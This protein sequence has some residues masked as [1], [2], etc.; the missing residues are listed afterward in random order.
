MKITQL[1]AET[2]LENSENIEDKVTLADD[3]NLIRVTLSRGKTAEFSKPT[4]IDL[5]RAENQTERF[6]GEFSMEFYRALARICC[7]RWGE[8]SEMPESEFIR[9]SD[10]NKMILEWIKHFDEAG[11]L[12]GDT[13][14]FTQLLD[15]GGLKPGFDAVEATLLNGDTLKFDEPSQIENQMLEKSDSTIEGNIILMSSLCRSWNGE[16]LS[17]A[18]YRVKINRLGLTDFLRL[19]K[20]LSFFQ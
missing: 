4:A 2:T 8:K 14:T 9:Q 18:E 5:Q 10:D 16:S 7:N 11:K 15:N 13:D 1:E 6:K 17:L 20:A 12:A 3:D 19:T